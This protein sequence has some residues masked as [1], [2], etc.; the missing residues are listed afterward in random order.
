[1]DTS[2]RSSSLPRDISISPFSSANAMVRAARSVIIELMIQETRMMMTTPF[3]I[4]SFIRNTPGSTSIFV[5]TITI[6]KAPAAWAL[7]KPN[8]IW[9]EEADIRHTNCVIQAATH[10]VKVATT[11]ITTTTLIVSPPLNKALKLISIPT[12]IRKYGMNKALPTNSVRFINGDTRGT[13]RFNTNPA[14]KAPKIPS[15]PANSA[16]AALR[17][18]SARTK[19]YCITLSS[20][21]RKNQRANRG[22]TR[23]TMAQYATH[24]PMNRNHEPESSSPL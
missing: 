4:S 2:I 5:P 12:P 20:Y 14:K 24:L 9:R 3:S 10:L 15:I 13:R 8:I 11:T 21:L 7:L 23:K 19:V 16:K 1:M 17:N 18:T 6:A 22:N